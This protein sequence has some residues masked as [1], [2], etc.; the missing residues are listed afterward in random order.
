VLR[1][2][3]AAG[4]TG[5]PPAAAWVR[6]GEAALRSGM[7]GE[8]EQAFAKAL[9]ADS[10]HAP[11]HRGLGSVLLMQGREAEAAKAFRQYLK[12]EPQAPDAG[13]IQALLQGL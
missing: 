7:A 9:A 8:A 10:G 4:A 12:L 5:A 6:K 2:R 1:A 3:S 13:R 11:A